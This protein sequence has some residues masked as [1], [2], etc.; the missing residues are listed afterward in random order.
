MYKN[1]IVTHKIFQCN[2]IIEIKCNTLYLLN[3]ITINTK[4][5]DRKYVLATK[6]N[7]TFIVIC[8]Y[9]IYV[10]YAAH[11]IAMHFFLNKLLMFFTIIT[12]AYM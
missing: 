9:E 4:A 2:E 10:T 7:Y 8:Q 5:K 6:S 11:S 3:V 12:D 1:L